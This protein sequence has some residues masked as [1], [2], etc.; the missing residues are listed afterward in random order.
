ML[1]TDRLQRPNRRPN[2]RSPEETEVAAANPGVQNEGVC[3]KRA[4]EILCT[5]LRRCPRANTQ[6]N[7]G[8]DGQDRAACEFH[9]HVATQILTGIVYPERTRQTLRGTRSSQYYEEHLEGQLHPA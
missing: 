3:A 2:H 4:A 1:T 6:G 9:V 7:H 8:P 5:K